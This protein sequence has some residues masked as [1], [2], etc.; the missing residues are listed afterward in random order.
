M[1]SKSLG[2][3]T[4]D[5]VAKVGSFEA[6]MDKAARKAKRS[7]KE[8]EDSAA[9][10]AKA[11][12]TLG[13]VLGTIGA[14]GALLK[15][16]DNTKQLEMQQ[17]QLAAVLRSTG[18]AA[19]YSREQLNAM[20][21]AMSGAS[22]FSTGDFAEAQTTLLAF[23][24]I[25]GDQFPVA[26]QAAADMAAR[27][28]MTVKAA[29]ETIGRALDVPSKGLG[30]LSDQGFRFTEEQ[31]DLA[32]Q[33]ES[34]G[35]T[36]E[37]Q[38]IIL[39]A[40][41]ESYA[42]A[43]QAARDTFSGALTALQNTLGDLAAGGDGSLD[44][45]TA[46][47]NGLND[48]LASPAAL[49]AVELL[50]DAAKVLAA[51]IAGRLVGSAAAS[52]VAFASAQIQ[53]ARYQAA[54][55]GMAG[56]SKAAAV[57]IGAVSVA[58]RAS[59]AAFALVGGPFGAAALAAIAIGSF[60]LSGREAKQPTDDLARSVRELSAAQREVAAIEAAK[61]IDE[62]S[63][64]AANL[65]ANLA[66]AEENAQGT[67]KRSKRFADDAA[68]M[69]VELEKTGAELEKYQKRLDDI[70]NFKPGTAPP[71]TGSAPAD[72]GAQRSEKARLEGIA[73]E[74]ESLERAA[75][76]WGMTADQVALYDLAAQGATEAQL[77]QAEASLLVVAGL[78]KQAD[79]VKALN[80]ADEQTNKEAASIIESLRTEE[81]AIRESY[82]RRRQ[83]ILDATLLTEQEKNEAILALQQEHDEEMI[84]ANGS[85][86]ERY[87][88][89]A[90]ENLQ[91][92]DE[93]S[94]VM[95][96]NFTGRFG[97]AFESM[98]FDAE[99]F[100]D[101]VSGLAEGMARSVVN[102]LGQMAAQ[103]VAY[104]AVQMLVGKTT[105]AS[106]ASTMT[107]NAM[108]S[109]QLAA[110]NAYASTA[111]IPITGAVMA[112]A[113]AAAAIAA[114]TPM[115]GA[116]ASLSLAG[117][118]HDGIDSIP[119]TGTW[120]LEKGERVTTA[121]TSAKLDK[122]LDEIK[123]K[124]GGGGGVTIHAPVT[125]EAQPGMSSADAQRQGTQIAKQFESVVM[126]VMA[127]EK[128]PGGI[129]A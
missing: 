16:V 33:L 122:T 106:A 90:E 92:F 45:A 41:Q 65:A 86:W 31:K 120:L 58:A 28:G 54:L 101:A 113:A 40:L 68:Y 38:A 19:G 66:Y 27:T 20:A 77:A 84:E 56:V 51:V 1:A 107:F 11:W 62:L 4:L 60:A 47:I 88:A 128:R 8:M 97:D 13:G 95:L 112:P 24:G 18:E 124:G 108:A 17:A 42:G 63:A 118:A 57:G 91:S 29:A 76:V 26:L 2:T 93:L 105:Q 100:G 78:E 103:W 126:Q 83:I 127:R 30:S 67:G 74:I 82:E 99:S 114:T 44:S 55:A 9:K 129:L 98:V 32:K 125:V 46:A 59:S 53:A 7:G 121:G 85:Y 14:G 94:G 117:M 81:E 73:R 36:A 61:K 89:A 80:D 12:K 21:A 111:A 69:R 87:L 39:D 25:V 52:A 115:V 48:A 72:K 23:T 102:A 3:L 43:A 70:Q 116:V 10:A 119:Q 50:T 79:A 35:R 6:G 15:V 34:T 109:Q 96:E 37:A 49:V 22:M 123:G 64:A 110:I 75:K 71:A 104:Q 5:L